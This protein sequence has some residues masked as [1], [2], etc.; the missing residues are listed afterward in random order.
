MTDITILNGGAEYKYRVAQTYDKIFN[1]YIKGK[2][3]TLSI[4]NTG[5]VLL[6]DPITPIILKEVR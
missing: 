4:V 1:G 5:S 2:K 3:L 6:V